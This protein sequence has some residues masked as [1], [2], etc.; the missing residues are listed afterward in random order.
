MRQ[1]TQLL[2][3]E[4]K[5]LEEERKNYNELN[6]DFAQLSADHAML[7]DKTLNQSRKYEQELKVLEAS[8]N[9][10][11]LFQEKKD[12]ELNEIKKNKDLEHKSF[13]SKLQALNDENLNLVNQLKNIST[14]SNSKEDE[15]GKQRKRLA[16]LTSEHEKLKTA[17]KNFENL[18][19]SFVEA[20]MRKEAAEKKL[21]ELEAKLK[22]WDYKYHNEIDEYKNLVQQQQLQLK[23]LKQ[24][25]TEES[26]KAENLNADCSLLKIES[27]KIES[28]KSKCENLEKELYETKANKHQLLNQYE[29]MNCKKYDESSENY[30]NE[31]KLLNSQIRNLVSIFN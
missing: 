15:L 1:Q 11:R 8:L 30:E 18:E 10:M 28:L 23:Q 3:Q 16:D 13:I 9:S 21:L 24:Q 31:N 20:N 27:N 17:Y 12:T 2:N 19:S 25:L 6:A 29:F 26:L 7:N 14:N 4:R 22:E 5:N